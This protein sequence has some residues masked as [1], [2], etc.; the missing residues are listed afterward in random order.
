[1]YNP[2]SLK[3]KTILITGASSGIGRITAIECSKLGA[4][5]F[6]NGRNEERLERTFSLLKGK[7]HQKILAD[8]STKEGLQILIDSLPELDGCVNNA[9][10]VK[11]VPTTFVT[12]EK[13]DEVLNINTRTPILLTTQLVKTKRLRKGSSIVFTSSISGTKCV[14]YGNVVYSVSKAAIEG[15]VKNAALDLSTKKIRVNCVSPG[16]ICTDL[17][18]EGIISKE[19]LVKDMSNYPLGRYGK[20]EEVAFGI[21]YLLSDAS[22]WT[23]GT[24]IVID[25][26][27]TLK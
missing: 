16:M 10:I 20:P 26:G 6:I 1:M 11:T 23:T 15:F 8:L 13:Y 18:S 4:I 21:I 17:F 14:S 3:G 22:S 19:Q 2:Y 5:V 25:G 24:S 9:G 7:G 27:Y 12:G